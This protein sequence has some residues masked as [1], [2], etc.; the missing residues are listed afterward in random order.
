MRR[1]GI[2]PDQLVAAVGFEEVASTIEWLAAAPS[3]RLW[4]SRGTG[5]P[6]P[7]RIDVFTPDGRYE[8]TFD[9]PGF[10][11]A[12]LSDSLFVAL[13]ITDLGEPVLGLYRLTGEAGATT[14]SVGN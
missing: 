2:T 4:V 13:E 14:V 6:V 7:D 12:V 8:G 5:L 3:G 9:A 11:V 1:T 10:P